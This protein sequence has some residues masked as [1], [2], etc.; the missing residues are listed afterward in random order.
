MPEIIE[1]IKKPEVFIALIGKMGSD[2]HLVCEY[3]EAILKTFAYKSHYIHVTNS[4]E[5]FSSIKTIEEPK[6]KRYHSY[7][8]ACNEV[9]KSLS[10]DDAMAMLA[11]KQIREQRQQILK[12]QGRPAKEVSPARGNAYIISQFKRPEEIQALRAVYGGLFVVISLYE[13]VS[14]R[15]SRLSQ[16]FADEDPDENKQAQW[17]PEAEKLIARD[18]EEERVSY[19]QKVRHAFPL[20]DFVLKVSKDGKT[21]QRLERFF[22]LFFSTPKASPEFDEIGM[23]LAF[24]ASLNSSDL[25]RQ[26]GAAIVDERG[27]IISTGYNE[28][29]SPLGSAYLANDDWDFRDVT[30]EKDAND[31][32]KGRIFKNLIFNLVQEG[33]IAEERLPAS[34]KDIY[35]YIRDRKGTPS[36]IKDS[37]LFDILEFSRSVHAEMH[38][39]TDAARRGVSLKGSTLFCTTFPCH[40]CAKHIVAAGIKRVVYMEP[41]PK[42]LVSDLHS[43]AIE[44]TDSDTKQEIPKDAKDRPVVELVKFDQFVGVAPERF[45][46][47]FR[48]LKKRKDTYGNLLHWSRVNASPIV[49]IYTEGYITVESS[50]DFKFSK[51]LS[52]LS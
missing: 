52:E 46:N 45:R 44:V 30:M 48:R 17:L 28:T 2:T 13:T 8:D 18:E 34:L 38:A 33:W 32:H 3:I 26:V 43:D 31:K 51:L 12:D 15:K 14:E 1:K 9:R 4:L 24:A 39:I 21:K 10:S 29:P 27:S 5:V 7:I 42:S 11:L 36:K 37:D 47:L 41:Y 50:V 40:N 20:A 16:L 6:Y 49:D 35:G 19:G 23:Y 25:S 22:E